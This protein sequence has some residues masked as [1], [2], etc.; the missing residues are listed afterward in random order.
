MF[1]FDPGPQYLTC[2]DQGWPNFISS[3]AKTEHFQLLSATH[4]LMDL[5]VTCVCVCVCVCESREN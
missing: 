3:R 1:E 5:K 4:I 2:V